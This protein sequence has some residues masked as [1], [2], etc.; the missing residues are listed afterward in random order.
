MKCL[1]DIVKKPQE[2]RFDVYHFYKSNHYSTCVRNSELTRIIQSLYYSP[3]SRLIQRKC[4]KRAQYYS[5]YITTIVSNMYI[6]PL[7]TIPLRNVTVAL[8][9]GQSFKLKLTINM[10]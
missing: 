1:Y 5:S 10:I 4:R 3:A 6:F 7:R 2:I 9:S 8:R